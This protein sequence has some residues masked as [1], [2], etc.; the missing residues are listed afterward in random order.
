[1]SV[2][3]P[4]PLVG[5]SPLRGTFLRH[6]S[7]ASRNFQTRRARKPFVRFLLPEAT[8]DKLY[9]RSPRHSSASERLSKVSNTPCGVRTSTGF[10]QHLRALSF[11]CSS[12]PHPTFSLLCSGVKSSVQP[13]RTLFSSGVVTL[14]HPFRRLFSSK[15]VRRLHPFLSALSSGVRKFLHFLSSLSSGES[16]PHHSRAASAFCSGVVTLPRF[17][18]HFSKRD[19]NSPSK[20]FL[21]HPQTQGC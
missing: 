9:R 7:G 16:L 20:N 13:A 17:L 2:R 11:L 1:M 12:F 3:F 10:P 6:P 4:A 18:C 19:N 8:G 14:S 15:V 21:S 5:L